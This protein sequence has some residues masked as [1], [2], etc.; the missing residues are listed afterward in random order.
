MDQIPWLTT[1]LQAEII[2]HAQTGIASDFQNPV[3]V[4]GVILEVDGAAVK[5]ESENCHPI[6][7]SHFTLHPD[8]WS[9]ASAGKCL[10]IY[11]SHPTV[12]SA[13]R[14]SFSDLAM[15]QQFKVP[16]LLWHYDGLW[17]YYDPLSA[18]P[19]P[20][21]PK[22]YQQTDLEFYLDWLWDWG[23]V[24]CG[25]L[26]YH[27]FLGRLG[28]ELI[29]PTTSNDGREIFAKGWDK[30]RESLILNGF[31]EVDDI[32]NNDIIL[33][34]LTCQN[35]HHGAIVVD[36]E[37]ETLLHITEPNDYTKLERWHSELK[38][39][40]ISVWRHPNFI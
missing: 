9:Q 35:A 40:T 28:I 7:S 34:N 8:V 10:A 33:M 25:R 38:N 14:L 23:R 22:P 24:C 36:A 15:A 6:P 18:N 31:T 2:A 27:Y 26:I 13:R 17:D 4:C 5:V 12:A 30:Y 39:K 3:E 19:Y 1:E 20:L 16:V 21:Q 11:H 29:M 37:N 32:Q